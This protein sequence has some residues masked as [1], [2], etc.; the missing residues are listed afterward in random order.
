MDGELLDATWPV[1]DALA[2]KREQ[3]Q[4]VVQINGKFRAEIEVPADAKNKDI[5]VIALADPRVSRHIGN[6]EVR[7]FVIVPGRLV[8]IVV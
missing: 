8:N 7:K 6:A 4:L 5:Q 1:V 2:L 3:V